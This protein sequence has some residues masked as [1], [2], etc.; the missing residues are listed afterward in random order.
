MM[1]P[2]RFTTRR[3][4]RGNVFAML[5]GAVALTGV[6]AA[7]SMQTLTGP[8]TTI[9][10]VTQRNVAENN[11][12]MNGKILV[13]A[14]VAGVSGGDADADGI[15][16][17]APFIAPGGGEAAPSNGGFLP[18]DL[19]LALTDPWGT[20]YGYCV[21]DHGTTNTSANRITGDNTASAST[22]PVIAIIAAGPDKT[23]Q[24]T[25][26]A[27]SGSP[28]TVSKASGSDDLI[29]HYTYA[30]ATAS[31][32][33]LWSLN[34]SDQAKAELKDSGGTARVTI[35]RST[36]IGDFLG[37]TTDALVAKTSNV[38]LD[39]G[40]K[41]DTETNVTACTAADAGVIRFNAASGKL[42]VCNGTAWTVAGS[43]LWLANGTHIYSGNTGNVGIGTN[44]PAQKL[45]VVGNAVISGDVGVGGDLGVTGTGTITGAATLGD[46]LSVT[47]AATLSSTLDVTGNT[48]IAANLTVD[49]NTLFVDAANNRV[50]IGTASPALPLTVANGAKSSATSLLA[51][52]GTADASNPLALD[53][54]AMG[55]ATSADRGIMLVPT[56]VG[57][58]SNFLRIGDT[59]LPH[60]QVNGNGNVGIG[61]ATPSHLLDVNGT[62]RIAGAAT[63]SNTLSVA[64]NT[65]IDIDTLFVNVAANTVGIGTTTP[66]ARLDVTGGVKIGA[67][68]VCNASKAGMVAWNANQFQVCDGTAFRSV[69]AIEKLDDIG[70]VYVSEAGTPNNN[71]ILAWDSTNTRW[72]AK[73]VNTVG[74]AVADP[75]G[76]DKQV[77]FNDGGT[78][79]GAAQLYWDKANNRLGIGTAT[80]GRTLHF[81]A[82]GQ[83]AI[84]F[85]DT[86]VGAGAQTLG[87][88]FDGGVALSKPGL[89]LQD[90]ND[91]GG[92]VSNSLTLF[93]DGS[94]HFGGITAPASPGDVLI[95]GKVGIGTA[96]PQSRLQV[97]GG[98]QL[99]DD[100]A[101]CPGSGNVKLGTLRFN[102][103]AL[104]VCVSGGWSGVGADTLS[105]LSCATNE[106]PKW[107]G[108]AWA[109]AAD[110]GGDT[111]ADALGAWGSGTYVENTSY[112]AATD[113]L[114]MAHLAAGLGDRCYILGKTDA[115][116][117]PTTVR[118]SAAVQETGTSD[119]VIV[120]TA[121]F[122]VKR[123]H[124]WRVDLIN[125]ASS[126]AGQVGISWIPMQASG[127]SDTLAG[128][129]CA[130]GEVAEWDGSAWAC[131]TGSG[132]GGVNA[133]PV[134]SFSGGGTTTATLASG[135]TL[136]QNNTRNAWS[137]YGTLPS[138]LVGTKGTDT[139]NGTPDGSAVTL[140]ISGGSALCYMLRNDS[141][142]SAV[143]TA[144]WSVKATAPGDFA[145][146]SPGIDKIYQRVFPPGS[147]TLDTYSAM[148][149]CS[150]SL[151]GG[152]SGSDTAAGSVA[153]A[154]QFNDGSDA[155]AADDLN[156]VWDD[157]NNRL[158]IGTASPERSLSLTGGNIGFQE[159]AQARS[160]VWGPAASSQKAAIDGSEGASSYLAF[161]TAS[162]ERLRIDSNGGVS[163]GSGAAA[164]ASSI[165]DLTS[166]T[167]G[168][169][170]PRMTTA[171]RNAISSPATGLTIYNTT[172]NSLDFFNGTV[173]S[174]GALTS[175]PGSKGLSISGTVTSA[176]AT[177]FN[178]SAVTTNTLLGSNPTTSAIT[179]PEAGNYFM[180]AVQNT[181]TGGANGYGSVT[182]KV[183]GVT[184][185]S[186]NSLPNSCDSATVG[187]YAVL[188][189]GDTVAAE[190]GQ[191]NAVSTT[192]YFDIAKLQ[193]D[194]AL[195]GGGGSSQ[196]T[197][198]TGGIN[199]AGGNVGVGTA[200]VP[201]VATANRR[202]L[203]IKGISDAGV[204]EL[205]G[206]GADASGNTAGVIQFI[207]P[208]F[209]PLTTTKTRIGAIAVRSSGTTAGDRGGV[210]EF[211]TKPDGGVLT[212][213]MIIDPDGSVSIGSG[214]TASASSLLDLTSTTKGFLPPRMTTA[215]RDAISSPATGLTIYNTTSSA[216]EYYNGSSWSAAVGGEV[217]FTAAGGTTAVTSTTWEDI[218]FPQI[219][220]TGGDNY[221]PTTGK[222]TAPSSGL[223]Q[224]SATVVLTGGS[225]TYLLIKTSDGGTTSGGNQ[226]C[227]SAIPN[228]TVASCGGAMYL[229]AGQVVEVSV[230][231][232]TSTTTASSR[233]QFSGFKVAAGSGGGG[234]SSQWTT[235][236]SDIHYGTGGVAV[237]QAA[238]PEATAALEIESTTKGFLP[239]RMT[240]TQRDAIA[241]PA[242]GLVVYNTTTRSLD[243]RVASSWLSFGGGMTGNTMVSGWPDAIRCDDAGTDDSTYV[244]GQHL[245]ASKAYYYRVGVTNSWIAFNNPG[246]TWNSRAGTEA[247]DCV[248]QSIAQLYTAGKAFNFVGGA[249]ASADG[250]SGQVQ[251]N[252]GGNLKADAA[253]Y[254]DNTNKRLGIGTATPAHSLEA[255][256]A[257]PNAI[258]ITGGSTNS[259]GLLISNTVA[260]GRSYSIYSS[261]G[262]P[263]SVGS[264]GIWDNT[265]STNRMIIDAS[266]NVGVG[267][268]S[269]SYKLDVAGHINSANRYYFSGGLPATGPTTLC[270][271]NGGASGYM[272]YCSSDR[273]LKENIQYLRK[274]DGL[275]AVMNL[276]PARFQWKTGNHRLSAGFIAQD[277]MAVIPEAVYIAPSSEF[278]GFDINAIV[279]YSVK[280][281]QEL[282]ADN[283]NLRA[284]L[285]AANDNYEE[286]RREIN[287]LKAARQ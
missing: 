4:E 94:A 213:R 96:T 13:N 198:V 156:L 123:G 145:S 170:P 59:N 245:Y 154:L 63:L 285:K 32:N 17:P 122:P 131:G 234:G 66:A 284:E 161:A 192:C 77:Q 228:Y 93:R 38:T 174:S 102:S 191:N 211:H 166:T 68:A 146:F 133:P 47:G 186:A 34:A 22:Q 117:T 287:A 252:E 171:Q 120:N 244:L 193:S 223:Y 153:G 107:N 239:P 51:R 269:P 196:W 220:E 29:E 81:S 151:V 142:W 100:T 215:Q 48:S 95:S 46:T 42:E 181:C 37:I 119:R 80:P 76:L 238:A 274:D 89:V 206:G 173:W 247:A 257:G 231:A 221:N 263:S 78:L 208:N 55:G 92:F 270:S 109:C 97:A 58:G 30:E 241:S 69:S 23:F 230:Q 188:A 127:G 268:T 152:G 242:E 118:A 125:E 168:F 237:G 126:C 84:A 26:P 167:K 204:L 104:Q 273:R 61:T 165:L 50:G 184:R 115:A 160:I 225:A 180:T 16:E 62:A 36:G 216:I 195:G 39:G 201:I 259:V 229:T 162:A 158:G 101:A 132:G 214:I 144:N 111:A 2:L 253:L 141:G 262:A 114:V 79:A 75:G 177:T 73:N 53:I 260:S 60:F 56:E 279:S 113:G 256:K 8:V 235:A 240:T 212:A 33:G 143:S 6:L 98:I 110:G 232:S 70:D 199:Y 236:G 219:S 176:S 226:I 88:V 19:G 85:S 135:M 276:K 157:T 251:F 40:L 218:V 169:L 266:G 172:T 7:V 286:L 200:T 130:A 128:L 205:A 74:S 233:S 224:F 264:F 280:A 5:F 249:T 44:N 72:V 248:G 182:I 15:I 209:T 267:T 28:V 243:L 121:T 246:G 164:A 155:F 163:I 112:L 52:L 106:I 134:I 82:A 254:W 14:A 11:L 202:F 190:C 222:F 35:D 87:L 99:G 185:R 12:L 255:V 140:T 129:S 9:T 148:Y 250:T 91:A 187:L 150:T 54:K 31:S 103:G 71:D 217:S 90:L 203:T 147:Y 116:A 159:S 105:G 281:I 175:L 189:A 278:Y 258:G 275:R 261:G 45:D 21:W 57:L 3:T 283:D 277:A 183:N 86:R 197:D 25:C 49:T 43:D 64:G 137:S 194:T 207:D 265:A 20:K 227:Y 136:Y 83:P 282:K 272:G 41:L 139:V 27:W 149:A 178:V 124:Y 1:R 10:R 67:D 24:T 108:T 138:Y 179:I 18:T 65:A 210:M 271:S